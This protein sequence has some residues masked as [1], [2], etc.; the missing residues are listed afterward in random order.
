MPRKK[1]KAAAA[2]AC[3]CKGLDDFIVKHGADA[4]KKL[5]ETPFDESDLL[6]KDYLMLLDPASAVFSR[7]SGKLISFDNFKTATADHRSIRIINGKPVS[8]PA[9]EVWKEKTQRRTRLLFSPA[10]KPWSL[11]D[12]PERE[13]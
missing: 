8:V 10:D 3:P 9:A 13:G 1:T 5:V 7:Q 4:F 12:D 2:A 6:D 11:I